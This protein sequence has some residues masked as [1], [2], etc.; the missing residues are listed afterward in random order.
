[1]TDNLRPQWLTTSRAA[2]EIGV[3]PITLLRKKEQG[4]FRE[5]IHYRKTGT[6]KKSPFVWNLEKVLEEVP[7]LPALGRGRNV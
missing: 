6:A 4:F 5:D 3:A 1:M 2:R 7:Y